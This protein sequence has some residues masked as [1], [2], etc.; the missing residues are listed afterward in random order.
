MEFNEVLKRRRSI[1]KFKQTE[2]PDEKIR[3]I[4]ELAQ[5]APTA[6][7]VQ[8][9]KVKIIK[10]EEGKKKLKDATFTSKGKGLKQ[11]W[12]FGAPV[13]LVICAD[14]EASESRFGERGKN[15]YAMQDAT[16]FASYLQLVIASAGMASCW[17]GNIGEEELKET[18]N[19][20]ND[21]KII[22]VIPFGYPDEELKP[23]ERKKL[24]EIL[25][26]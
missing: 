1:R 10:S 25:L 23:Q 15:L 20:P 2:I 6:G 11:E 13:I 22:A 9:Y 19:I 17:V 7:N 3:E 18:L 5:L 12:V 8:A 4:L 26:D 16:I 14:I 21:L 24:E